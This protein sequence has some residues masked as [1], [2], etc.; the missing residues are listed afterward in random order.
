L[1]ACGARVVLTYLRLD[2]PSDPGLPEAYRRDRVAAARLVVAAIEA[3]GGTAIEL[4]ADLS[5]AESHARLF[6]VAEQRNGPVDILVNNASGWMADSF[7]PAHTTSLER[8]VGSISTSSF[9]RNFAVDAR[10]SALLIGEFA[11]RHVARGASWGRIVGLT[12]GGPTGFPDEVSYGAAKAAQ[13]N[14]TMSAAF[15]LAVH[16][17]TANLVHP[18]VTHTGWVTPAGRSSSN[19]AA[20][21]S[22]SP[23]PTR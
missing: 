16:G 4:E 21:S 22:T 23:H 7:L 19:T 17:I 3:E 20:S 15:E 2:P 10:A 13:E 9:D 12:F 18:P 11:R 8:S 1:A 14:L 6:D 5:D